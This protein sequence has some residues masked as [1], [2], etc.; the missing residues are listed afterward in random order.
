MTSLGHH[1]YE[2]HFAKLALTRTPTDGSGYFEG[3]ASTW[4]VDR[5]DERF[6]FG[7][8][9]ESITE[10]E[11]IGSMPGL[12]FNHRTDSPDDIIGRVLS[13]RET[14]DGLLISGQL[15]LGNPRAVSVYARMMAGTLDS[16][17]VGYIPEQTRGHDSAVPLSSR[18]QTCLR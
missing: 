2:K 4:D 15:D 7:A 1:R 3:L 12:F 18:R 6:A 13:M 11:S 14:V 5:D 16:M 9:A 17:S 8:W 10:W